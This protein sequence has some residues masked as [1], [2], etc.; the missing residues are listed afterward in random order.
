MPYFIL[1]V[2]A[3][4]G[5]RARARCT[6]NR[7]ASPESAPPRPTP[8]LD[9]AARPAARVRAQVAR[10]KC[11]KSRHAAS[12]VSQCGC[13]CRSSAPTASLR[14]SAESPP[15]K[16]ESLRFH[17]ELFDKYKRLVQIESLLV[18]AKFLLWLILDFRAFFN[19][20]WWTNLICGCLQAS[21][22]VARGDWTI[23]SSMEL[24][25]DTGIL[26]PI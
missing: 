15:S 2:V 6:E 24:S 5:G 16:C 19:I 25:R 20:E 18:L 11:C 14:R 12:A 8:R 1:F 21:K 23:K 10:R 3:C 9:S 17:C 13:T 26:R 4:S 22:N 7:C